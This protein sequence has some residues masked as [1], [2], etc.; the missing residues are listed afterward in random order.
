VRVPVND[1]ELHVEERGSGPAV[2]LVHGFPDTSLLWR[3]QVPEL[4]AAGYRVITLDL[5]GFGRSDKPHDVDAY[6]PDKLVGDLEG[7]LDRLDVPAVHLVGHDWGS[8]L[9]WVFA[10]TRPERVTS[11]ACLS[12]GHP[13]AYRAAGWRQRQLGW[14]ALLFQ[15]DVAEQWLLQDDARNLREFLSEHPD[16][17]EVLDS[18]RRPGMITPALGV[19]RAWTPPES[20]VEPMRPL[21]KIPVPVLGVWSTND[22]FLTEDQMIG[23]A[24]HVSGTFRYERMEDA[25]HWIPLDCPRRTTDLL[26]DFFEKG[27]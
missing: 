12:T 24:A 17:D 10:A 3:E 7:V 5:R 6:L 27:A 26:I 16:V 9:S 19:Y 2:L 22:R 25:G 23:S 4:A 8:V 15:F 11:L 18:L 20:L 21:P 1:I 13:A 14:Y